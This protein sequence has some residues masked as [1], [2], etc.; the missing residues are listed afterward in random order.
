MLVATVSLHTFSLP[1]PLPWPS[2]SQPIS[3]SKYLL[4]R[5]APSKCCFGSCLDWLPK[6]CGRRCLEW[7]LND[8][9][10]LLIIWSE[11]LR[12]HSEARHWTGHWRE[13]KMDKT[14][15]VPVVKIW[16]LSRLR[17]KTLHIRCWKRDHLPLD[18]GKSTG[19]GC[20]CLQYVRHRGFQLMRS[21]DG[22]DSPLPPFP[23]A[24]LPHP[25]FRDILRSQLHPVAKV[26]HL[27]PTSLCFLL[28]RHWWY[29]DS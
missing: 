27:H 21:P 26:A 4:P 23:M 10:C 25:S 5:I 9:Q 7:W 8:F 2:L 16:S 15:C 19:N 17:G 13:L 11:W 1:P 18:Q 29:Q 12:C 3:P 6:L 24:H 22:W 20:Q 28:C 14:A